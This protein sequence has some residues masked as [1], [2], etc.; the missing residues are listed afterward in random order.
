[1][2]R[3]MAWLLIAAACM[4]VLAADPVELG[5]RRELFVD[6]YLI[7]KLDGAEL[8]L[9]TPRDEGVAF[10]LDKPWEG[11]FSA[12]TTII[13]DGDKYRAYYRGLPES[14]ADGSSRESTCYAESA[15][16]KT[17]T[18]PSLG[19]FEVD[20]TKENNVILAGQPPFSHNFCP[21]IDRRKGV[22]AEERYKALAG[23]SR[24][25][26]VAWI[27][28]DGIRWKKLREEPVI[29]GGAFD[30]QNVP[31]WSEAE[32]CYA[33]YYRVFVDRVRR[34]ARVTSQ[35]FA[36]WSEPTLMGYSLQSDPSAK[37]PIEQL[38]TN[39]TSPYFRAPHIYVAIAARFFPG[40]RVLTPEQAARVGVDPGYFNDCSDGILMTT[41]GGDFYDRTFME[42]FLKPGLGLENW[43]SRTN[44]PALNVVQTGPE[45]MSLYV[46]QNYGQP[47]AH[48][49]RYSLRHDGF[50]ALHAG[51]DGGEMLTRPLTFN[52]QELELNFATSAAGSIRVEIQDAAG[53]PISGFTAEECLDT[54]GNELDR[55]VQWKA[56]SDVSDLAGQ[57]L[58]LRFLLKDADLFSLRFK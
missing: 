15:D 11:K 31:L 13:P 20:G 56:G 43:T 8:R 44:Y 53:K 34:I 16:G 41:R 42:G 48:I 33:C 45:E 21:L 12:Y 3:V 10:A 4:D 17:W 22:P 58:R 28:P 24:T 25:G 9:Q 55:V 47:T 26:L 40:K 19:L 32:Q 7:E 38:Y 5:S 35:D 30:S 27:S 18:K 29:T 57:P 50:A 54:I 39:Q 14:R 36:T 23:S 6:G 46:N 37:L 51:Y 1:M 52:G 49:H 2:L